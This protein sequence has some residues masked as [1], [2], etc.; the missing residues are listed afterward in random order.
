MATEQS[1]FG[2]TPESI[3]QA[4]EAALNTQ[5]AQYAQ[6]DPFQQASFNIYRGA[7][8]LGGAV[9]GMLGG[10][11]PQMLQMQQRQALLQGIDL[12]NPQS[13]LAAAQKASQMKDYGAAQELS[14]KA[15]A[16]TLASQKSR[17]TEANI[18]AKL[19]EKSTTEMKNAAALAGTVAQPGT[20]E[21]TAAFNK[22]LSRLNTKEGTRDQIKEVGVAVGSNK[23]VYTVQTSDGIRQ[24]T[25]ETGE[26]GKQVMRPYVGA[27]DR[28]TAKV[29]AT[30]S[31]SGEKAGAEQIAKLDA[32]R[33]SDA[34]ISS[35]KALEAVGL[36]TTLANT[37]Q[38]ISGAG[39][40]ARVAALRVLDTLGL[41][42]PK[43]R[44]ALQ[45]AD[46]FNSLA[47][48]RVLSFIKQL[49]SNPTDTDREF[50][51]TI[52]PALEKGTKTNQD[53]INY[54]SGRANDTV[55]AA[56]AM[57]KHFYDNNY[58]LKGFQSPLMKN[59]QP[60]SRFEGMSDAEL[61]ARIKN[62]QGK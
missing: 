29:S 17:E 35:D 6:L 14:A 4:R 53:L 9:G 59:L 51:R 46:T 1:L 48:E 24:I 40:P 34:N 38:P 42:G 7:N 26:D 30:A 10:T 20:P 55:K 41:T 13:L 21:W 54:L 11:D 60:P 43:D 2:A 62:L 33:L 16:L 45:N 27:V 18:G 57:E 22:E 36:L 31:A 8:Q 56:S 52:G 3:Q 50:A 37:P 47:G 58:S 19:S 15:Q 28:T 44:G 32:K 5:A 61:A 23:P 12:N 25:F 49:G 39:A